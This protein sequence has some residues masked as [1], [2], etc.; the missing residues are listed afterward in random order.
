MRSPVLLYCV[1]FAL[2]LG[3]ISCSQGASGLLSPELEAPSPG[4]SAADQSGGARHLWGYW[5]V[6]IDPRTGSVDVL[7]IRGIEFTANVTVFLQPPMGKTSNL[8][9]K[10]IDASHFMDEGLIDV[11]VTLIHPFPGLDMY[12]G[13]DVMGVFVHDGDTVGKYDGDVF[14]A[15][16]DEVGLLLNADGYTRWYN[17]K[18]FTGKG[19]LG[20][21]EGALGNKGMN[22]TATINP[23][24]Y[25]C[26]EL[27]PDE[28]LA[29]FFYK[30]GMIENRGSFTSTAAN[31]RLYK[32]QFPFFGPEPYLTFQ[33]AV[34][35]NW[36]PPDV[37]PPHQIPEDF[38]LSANAREAFH[39]SIADNGSSLFYS[40]GAGGGMVRIRAEL[41]DWGASANPAGILGEFSR[42]IIESPNADILGDYQV[43]TPDLFEPYVQPGTAASSVAE[44]ELEG[45]TPVS[46]D[47]VQFLVTVESKEGE[48]YEQ[49]FGVPIP[50]GPLASYWRFSLPVGENPC[51]DF[52]VT[53]AD[54][55]SAESGQS[56]S[57]FTVYGENFQD[58][59]NLAV[60]IVDGSDVM[61][62]ATS[63][64]HVDLG[65]L[66]CDLDFCGVNPG[67]YDLRVTNGCDPI[68]YAS[69]SY[70]V[71]P[72]PLKN[73]S[74]REGMAVRDLGI[75]ET[76]GEPYVLFSDGEI[77]VYNENYSNGS[78][79][80]ANA[81][82][83][84]IDVL[85]NGDCCLGDSTGNG[86]YIYVLTTGWRYWGYAGPMMDVTETDPPGLGD[87]AY[88]WQNAGSYVLSTRRT[89]TAYGGNLAYFYIVGSGPGLVNLSAFRALHTS[90]ANADSYYAMWCYALEGPPEF[91]VER[92][93]YYAAG[94]AHSCSHD[95]TIC[96]SQGDG[97]NQLNDPRDISGDADDNIY[98]LES[99][100]SGQPAV[101]V[102]DMNGD[103]LGAFGDSVSISGE[104]LRL[105]VDEGDGEVHVVHTDGVSIF[106]PCEIPI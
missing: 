78:P 75:R 45:V 106:R 66:A 16:T 105:D 33:Y 49:G 10:I 97:P 26:D 55:P 79:L 14:Y 57:P 24:K 80:A 52:S 36:E 63:V 20:F 67:E 22:F 43:F 58:G 83:D 40:G 95:L 69:I 44:L 34:V 102:Y 59:D 23:Y 56:Y 68:S 81:A 7:P 61:A 54:P 3:M 15:R 19:I 8:R 101:K 53:G 89:P 65:T 82:L 100:S 35:A 62:S 17:P 71:E 25:F 29:D 4:A 60:D 91:A 31:T 96:G 70:M 39:L 76:T 27:K 46:A 84:F 28:E 98:I 50:S 38:P 41:F 86:Q 87:R 13:F 9:I 48:T 30:P 88:F 21:V 104:P 99:F 85:D 72:D 92:Y 51:A 94:G 2:L 37:N 5:Q 64:V 73:I 6:G 90:R 93:D 12:T 32:L 77:W 74:L 42:V 103:Y 47:D 1:V 11:E 18:E